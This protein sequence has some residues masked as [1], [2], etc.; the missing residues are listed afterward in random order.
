MTGEEKTIESFRER[1]REKRAL[2]KEVFGKH[3]GTTIVPYGSAFRLA[4]RFGIPATSTLEASDADFMLL[5]E[6]PGIHRIRRQTVN[7]KEIGYIEVS[8]GL[9]KADYPEKR[10]PWV[11]LLPL[12][13]DAGQI[14][15]P[16]AEEIKRLFRK[17]NEN[18]IV[19]ALERFRYENPEKSSVKPIE[20]ADLIIRK[21]ITLNEM[22]S[23][24][25]RTRLGFV[26]SVAGNIELALA[27]LNRAEEPME[28]HSSKHYPIPR[29]I[30]PKKIP[31][32]PLAGLAHFYFGRGAW[33]LKGR[34]ARASKEYLA[35]RRSVLREKLAARHQGKIKPR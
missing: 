6:K 11:R 35:E 14:E 16:R 25:E 3:E 21:M 13:I 18:S 24:G 20:L 5:T 4:R 34:F 27:R 2:A 12:S 30:K 15:G 32:H 1:T 29:G 10:D 9:F 8:A 26:R 7:G 23:F 17:T 22:A 19:T 31:L 33:G 28:L